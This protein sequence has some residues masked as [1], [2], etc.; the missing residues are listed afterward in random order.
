MGRAS[1]LAY[2]RHS[3][4]TV[5]SLSEHE[6]AECLG[7][8][9]RAMFVLSLLRGL[10]SGFPE[11]VAGPCG[12]VGTPAGLSAPAVP[13]PVRLRPVPLSLRAACTAPSEPGRWQT[14]SEWRDVP[15]PGPPRRQVADQMARG[16]CRVWQRSADTTRW[17][18]DVGAGR[19]VPAIPH[20][21][22]VSSCREL[23]FLRSIPA[24]LLL[25]FLVLRPRPW[26]LILLKQ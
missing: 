23:N 10:H 12:P 6:T 4:N 16:S 1:C 25:R 3:R 26:K 15:R 19:I 22:N 17:F 7:R 11:P 9:L 20:R 2:S 13:R 8:D 24:S 21:Q 18:G 5:A 14:L